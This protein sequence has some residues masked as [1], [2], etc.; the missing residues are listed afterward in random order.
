MVRLNRS[1]EFRR[2]LATILTAHRPKRNF[3]KMLDETQG[4]D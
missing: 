3:T 4:L 1:D 2:Y